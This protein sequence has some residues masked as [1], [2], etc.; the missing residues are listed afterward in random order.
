MKQ[1]SQI[2]QKLTIAV[3]YFLIY[4]A[5]VFSFISVSLVCCSWKNGFNQLHRS[6]CSRMG[7]VLVWDRK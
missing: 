1:I 2:K 7:S 5:D 6:V 3:A 4:L